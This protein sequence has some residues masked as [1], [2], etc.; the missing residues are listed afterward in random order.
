VVTTVFNPASFATSPAAFN[1]AANA[2]EPAFWDTFDR[3]SVGSA[4]AWDR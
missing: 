3:R 1:V 4:L 2:S